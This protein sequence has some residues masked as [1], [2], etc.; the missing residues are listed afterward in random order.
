MI[1]L[2]VYSK[3]KISDQFCMLWIKGKIGFSGLILWQKIDTSIFATLPYK[4]AIPASA[5]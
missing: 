4:R 2:N 1:H 5:S 3:P